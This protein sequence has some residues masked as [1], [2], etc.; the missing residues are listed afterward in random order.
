MRRS[1]FGISSAF[2]LIISLMILPML[3]STVFAGNGQSNVEVDWLN[4]FM[5]LFGGLALFLAGL[6]MLSEGLK[7]AA[8]EALKVLLSQMTNNR[9]MGHRLIHERRGF[10]YRC[11]P[12]SDTYGALA[13]VSRNYSPLKGRLSAYY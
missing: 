11:I 4:L 3:F 9:L 12:A 6:D 5:G 8:G 7:K 2:G 1:S 10:E 13:S